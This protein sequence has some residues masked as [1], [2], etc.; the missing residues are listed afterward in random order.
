MTHLSATGTPSTWDAVLIESPRRPFTTSWPSPTGDRSDHDAFLD[1]L[2][3]HERGETSY[4]EMS[5]GLADSG[6][7]RWSVDTHA[8]TMTFYD[9]SGHALLV[10][11]IT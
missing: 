4:F 1:H 3:R 2:R 11:Q 7:G 10:E 8:M 9:R 5:K 6:I